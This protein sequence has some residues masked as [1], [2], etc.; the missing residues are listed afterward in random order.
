MIVLTDTREWSDI[1]LA[2]LKQ[3]PAESPPGGNWR[4]LSQSQLSNPEQRLWASMGPDST[5][6]RCEITPVPGLS[7]WDYLVIIDQAS[8]S[9]FD[10]LRGLDPA[11]LPGAVASVAI[12][13]RGF[14]GHHARPWET[15]RGNLHLSTLCDPNLDAARCG[16]AMTTLPAVAVIDALS[17]C[18]PWS[19]PPGIKWVNDILIEG[20]KVAGVLTATQSVRGRLTGLTLGIGLNVES[21]PEVSATPFVPAAGCLA[22]HPAGHPSPTIGNML[23]GCLRALSSRLDVVRK[24]GPELLIQAYRDNSL[25][26]GRRVVIWPDHPGLD[27]NEP[28]ARGVVQSIGPDLSLTLEGHSGPITRGRLAFQSDPDPH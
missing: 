6:S 12:T 9:Q 21:T 18:G 28:L 26:L 13:G 16:L 20:R 24:A 14:H 1:L 27:Q 19:F 23:A 4:D 17:A 8:G 15:R 5:L 3:G 2:D 25:V 10:I 11:K 22:D 7:A